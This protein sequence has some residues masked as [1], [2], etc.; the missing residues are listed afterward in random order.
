[1]KLYA[2]IDGGQSSTTAVVGDER[3]KVLGR[4]VG[5]PADE[6]G[7]SA[8]STRLRDALE[9][10]LANALADASLPPDAR[11]ESVVAGVSGYDGRL[12]G[13]EPMVNTERL[14]VVH[15]AP[16]AHAGALGGRP[17]IIVIAGTGSVVY[18]VAP[19]GH[20]LTVGGWGYLFGDEG[21]AFWIAARVL[22]DA[23]RDEDC[24]VQ[25]Q[26]WKIACDYFSVK[27]MR[28]IQSA[29]YAGTLSR[30]RVASFARHA[31]TTVDWRH[32]DGIV[33]RGTQAL[34]RLTTIAAMRL[35][36]E[37]VDV[38]LVGGLSHESRYVEAFAQS[39]EFSSPTITVVP[40]EA[41]PAVG[42]LRMAL[43]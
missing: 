36:F 43:T 16:I 30:D 42:A 19:D 13:I 25:T 24:A 40:A 17:G 33:R 10:A 3:G 35:G 21:S 4:S 15:D 26:P 14:Q 41:E 8:T 22:A 37:T 12:R 2:G 9:G 18:G 27:A 29:F 23:M 31:L 11:F 7:Q 38:A 6:L 20:S 39:F 34:G 5:G 32:V 28:E 1:M